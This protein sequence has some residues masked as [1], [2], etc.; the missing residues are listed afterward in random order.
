MILCKHSVNKFGCIIYRK[1]RIITRKV[2][3]FERAASMESYIKNTL[4]LYADIKAWGIVSLLEK[5]PL[6]LS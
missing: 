2:N 6:S 4:G 1:D 5:E 3:Y